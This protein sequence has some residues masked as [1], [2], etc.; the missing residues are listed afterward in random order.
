MKKTKTALFLFF[1]ALP[2]TA[3]AMEEGT[4]HI[5][6][7]EVDLYFMNDKVFGTVESRPLWAIYNCG[8]DIK[9]EIDIKG[10]Y[11]KFNFQ[12]QNEDDRKIIGSFGSLK[13]GLGKIEKKERKFI[14]HLFVGE[15]EYIFS[16]KYEKTEDE[17]LVNSLIEGELEKKKKIRLKVDGHLCPFATTG[18]ILIVA[19]SSVL[20]L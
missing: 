14:Y 10:T 2:L 4:R 13:M 8:S 1:L 19:G 12:F 16:I 6:G 15:K 17:H 20:S 5:T 9:G 18:I 11:H 3:F 7:K